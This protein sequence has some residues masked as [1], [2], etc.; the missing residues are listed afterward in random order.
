MAKGV[1]TII[2]SWFFG[3]GRGNGPDALETNGGIK[4]RSKIRPSTRKKQGKKE[5]REI[6]VI[7]FNLL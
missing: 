5:S 2:F 1:P 3:G 4:A 6:Y 7:C